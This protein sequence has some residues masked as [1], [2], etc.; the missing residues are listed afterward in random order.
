M[1]QRLECRN[2]HRCLESHEH[3][4]SLLHR[5]QCMNMLF[6]HNKLTDHLKLQTAS[7]IVG[8]QT[9]TA[10]LL[11]KLKVHGHVQTHSHNLC[12]GRFKLDN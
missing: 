8:L 9:Q 10:Q 5:P 6:L 1:Q 12:T 7:K 3:A 11:A 2:D 4:Q